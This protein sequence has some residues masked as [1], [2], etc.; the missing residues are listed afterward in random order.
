MAYFKVIRLRK[1][2]DIAT[3]QKADQGKIYEYRFYGFY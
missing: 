3:L 1:S 2:A